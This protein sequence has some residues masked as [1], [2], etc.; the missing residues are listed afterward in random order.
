[1]TIQISDEYIDRLIALFENVRE[2]NFEIGDTLILLVDSSPDQRTEIMNYVA[3]KLAVAPSTLYDYENTARRWSK[4]DRV[5]YASLDWTIYRN[6]DPEK[7]KE[8]LDQAIDEG[9]NATTF[10]EKMFPAM[11][12]PFNLV[13]RALRIL[14]KTIKAEDLPEELVTDFRRIIVM[15]SEL[16]DKLEDVF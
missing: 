5:V 7:D 6:S 4:D 14:Q 13:E 10:K 2:N 16:R 15:L 11:N 9:W 12:E 3:G 1:M 8:L